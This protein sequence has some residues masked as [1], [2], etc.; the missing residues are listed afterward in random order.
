M[1]R[2]CLVLA[3]G[4]LV[5]WLASPL[6]AQQ[7]AAKMFRETQHD[8]GSVARGSKAEYAFELQNLYL[9]DVHIAGVRSSCGCTL[10][11]VEKDTLKTYE[12]GAIIAR[13]NTPAFT[14]QKGA[15]VTVTFDKPYYAEVQLQVRAYI[16]G[17][18]AFDPPGVQFESVEQGQ[19]AEARVS[20]TCSGRSDWRILD[21]R[22]ANP[23][24]KATAVERQRRGG[25]VVYDVTVTLDPATPPGYLA[26]HLLL[27]TNDSSGARVPL[28]VEGR[29]VPS[30]TVSPGS[31]FLGVVQPGQK[32][33]KQLIVKGKRPFRI[34][35][36]RAE[37]GGFVFDTSGES[38]PKTVHLIPV[39]FTAGENPGKLVERIF[40]Q[41]DLDDARP[42]LSAFAVVAKP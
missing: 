10:P 30:V 37:E 21:V 34:V 13:I 8:F 6:P 12:K 18:L 9:E 33:T 15:T 35:A 20:V 25:Q 7:W 29:V 16:R 31:L 32:V 3:S 27:V 40:I 17:E 1:L 11:R 23:H 28:S 5:S 26:D 19:G 4:L 22:A 39:T 24:L 41:T 38:E 42:E 36:I 2:R 14:G